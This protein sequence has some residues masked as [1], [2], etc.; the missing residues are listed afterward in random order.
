MSKSNN[1]SQF[2]KILGKAFDENGHTAKFSEGDADTWI[3]ET[4][5]EF[6]E[7][8]ADAWIAETAMEFLLSGKNI[9]VVTGDTDV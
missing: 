3:A 7:S 6:S 1:K 4:A 2:I 5:L 8:D 9:T